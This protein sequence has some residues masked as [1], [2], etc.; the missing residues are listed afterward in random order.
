MST[1][2]IARSKTATITARPENSGGLNGSV[3]HWLEVYSQEFQPKVS[4]GRRLRRRAIA[5]R[6]DDKSIFDLQRVTDAQQTRAISRD[7]F[8]LLAVVGKPRIGRKVI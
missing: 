3:Q 1:S 6:S 7:K 4:R 2:P 8:K 5:F